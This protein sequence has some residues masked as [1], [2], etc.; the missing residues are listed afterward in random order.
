MAGGE[1]MKKSSTVF[2]TRVQYIFFQYKC[3]LLVQK[4]FH[5]YRLINALKNTFYAI[6][7]EKN[8][9]MYK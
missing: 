8:G 1:E 2:H 6:N 9:K 7:Y 5:L 4:A 3:G